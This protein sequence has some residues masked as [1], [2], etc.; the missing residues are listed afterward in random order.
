MQISSV[1]DTCNDPFAADIRKGLRQRRILNGVVAVY[2]DELVV[3]SSLKLTPRQKFKRSFYGT[4]SFLPALFGLNIAACVINSILDTKYCTARFQQEKLKKSQKI[5][6]PQGKQNSTCTQ[7]R[8]LD[9]TEHKN[10]YR[11]ILGAQG[12]G[13]GRDG[14]GI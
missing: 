10:R 5:V 4:I 3:R 1:F 8:E 14:D 11:C 9:R 13:M 7:L 2:S 12:I 6:M